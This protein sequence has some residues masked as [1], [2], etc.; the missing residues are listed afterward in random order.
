L[1][2]RQPAK[3]M[4]AKPLLSRNSSINSAFQRGGWRPIIVGT[5]A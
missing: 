2:L 1:H 5:F 4:W 3:A